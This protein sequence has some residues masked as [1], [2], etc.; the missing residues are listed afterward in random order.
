MKRIF[1]CALLVLLAASTGCR[2]EGLQ[3]REDRGIQIVAP[4]DR[5]E[6]NLPIVVKWKVQHSNPRFGVFINV[7]PQPPGEGLEYFF[8]KDPSCRPASTCVVPEILARVGVFETTEAT[9]TIDAVGRRMG[10]PKDQSDWHEV[11]VALLDS[12]GRRIGESGDWVLLK[13]KR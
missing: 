2:T 3:F 12:N 5:A 4:A 9:F 11:T 1:S 7:V 13:L 10:V 8:R 6:V